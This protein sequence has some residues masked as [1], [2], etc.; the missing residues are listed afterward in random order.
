MEKIVVKDIEAQKIDV[1]ERIPKRALNTL[2]LAEKDGL[3]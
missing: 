1:K 3:L 2:S